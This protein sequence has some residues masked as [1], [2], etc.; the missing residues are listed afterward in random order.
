MLKA[1]VF[2]GGPRISRTTG[3]AQEKIVRL[4]S[5]ELKLTTESE[6]FKPSHPPNQ[7][8]RLRVWMREGHMS[9]D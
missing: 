4:K 1:R 8:F 6:L 5:G 7:A 3:L 2:S 9:P